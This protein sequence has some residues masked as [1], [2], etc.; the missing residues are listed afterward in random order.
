MI[1]LLHRLYERSVLEPARRMRVVSGP[2]GARVVLEGRSVLVLCSDNCLGLAEHP[3]AREAAAD[4][5]LR[6]GAGAGASRLASGTMT[7][8]C[9]LEDELA[10]FHGTESALLFGSGCEAYSGV[11]PAL[12]DRV[13][14]VFVDALNHPASVDGCRLSGAEVFAYDHCDVEHLEW[15]LRRAGSRGAL[16]VTEGVFALD[17]DVAPLAEIAQ[18]A[19]S[20]GVRMLVDETHGIGA[21]GPG[22]RGAVAEA[23]VEDDVDVLVGSL[24]SALGTSGAYVCGNGSLTRYLLSTAAS[25]GW[26]TAPPP[27]SA[28]GAL[29]ALELILE[30]PRRVDKLQANGHVLREALSREGF[31]TVGSA[32]HIV[33]VVVGPGELASRVAELAIGGGV[34]AGAVGPSEAARLRLAVMASHTKSELRDAAQVLGR[35]A[36]LGGFRPGSGLPL[37]AAQSTGVSRHEFVA[38]A[39]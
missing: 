16:I 36:L 38:Q 33:P 4:A 2:Q 35:A 22:G 17:G 6:W 15:G 23:G 1:D 27:P 31:D 8:H 26:G 19:G 29:A 14:V 37:L 12:A 5:A 25:L 10:A 7:P 20:F 21:L 24:G 30:Q 32:T 9:R 3:R 11:V 18:L 34:F 13:D 39:A 28:A